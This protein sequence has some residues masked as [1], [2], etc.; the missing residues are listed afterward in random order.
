M[1]EGEKCIVVP[2]LPPQ[3][4]IMDMFAVMGLMVAMTMLLNI[5]MLLMDLVEGLR[6][7][8]SEKTKA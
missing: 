2:V 6:Y 8:V 5:V 1:T 3:P 7:A 4:P